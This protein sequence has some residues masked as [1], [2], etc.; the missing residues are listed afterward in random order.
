MAN[1]NTI[2]IVK[3]FVDIQSSPEVPPRT[4]KQR[5]EGGKGRICSSSENCCK[6]CKGNQAILVFC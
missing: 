4:E 5:G 3:S 6:H 1:E 2:T